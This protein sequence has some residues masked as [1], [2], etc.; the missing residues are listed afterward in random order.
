M[1]NLKRYVGMAVLA[2][3]LLVGGFGVI[4]TDSA[5]AGDKNNKAAGAEKN[6]R[7]PHIRKAIAELREAKKELQKADHDFGGHRV[8]AIEAVDTAIKQLEVALKFD[9]K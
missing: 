6:E 2:G 1:S 7:H 8:E 5:V 4:A 3:G 9:K